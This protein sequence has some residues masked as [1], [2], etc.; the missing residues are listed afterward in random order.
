[1]DH[2]QGV[3]VGHGLTGLQGELH[4]LVDGKRPLLAHPR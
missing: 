1:M 2:A 3:R 4:R